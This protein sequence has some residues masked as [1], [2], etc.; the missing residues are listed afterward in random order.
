[1]LWFLKTWGWT[2][3]T[4]RKSPGS[5]KNSFLYY[6]LKRF[7]Q[8]IVW[9]ELPLEGL[10]LICIKNI[11]WVKITASFC[12]SPFGLI[13]LQGKKSFHC[14]LLGKVSDFSHFI[15]SPFQEK[16]FN[17]RI[18]FYYSYLL[19]T[20]KSFKPPS[21]QFDESEIPSN[22]I[23]PQIWVCSVKVIF[24]TGCHHRKKMGKKWVTFSKGHLDS[25]K[26]ANLISQAPECIER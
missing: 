14:G 4:K 11:K 6:K 2:W 16:R 5:T 19:P 7:W 10:D 1:M 17:R 20:Y 13:H 25:F 15:L 12:K 3:D 8:L 22:N 9:T 26:S 23:F 18:R 21:L 24:I